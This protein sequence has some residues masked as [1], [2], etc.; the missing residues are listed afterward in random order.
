VHVDYSKLV[1]ESFLDLIRKA[2]VLVGKSGAPYE[3]GILINIH[4]DH[5]D[6]VIP[7][8]IRANHPDTMSIIL[9]NMFE[10]LVVESDAFSVT[11]HFD[12]T[13][14]RLAIPLAAI[15]SFED[16]GQSIL[17][18]LE[19]GTFEKIGAW[20]ASASD[21]DGR[22]TKAG[23]AEIIKLDSFRKTQGKRE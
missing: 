1:F 8:P 11:L 22:A 23:P 14:A 9:Q 10:D 4:T 16:L 5:P 3:S 20:G 21:G 7:E 18:T 13:P 19:P 17:F 6:L 2:L 15:I 12:G